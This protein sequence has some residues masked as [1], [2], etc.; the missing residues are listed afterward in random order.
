MPH[1]PEEIEYSDKYND[2]HYEYRHVI[3]TKD[4]YRKMQRNRLLLEKVLHQ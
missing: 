2:E 1:Y 4:V 3:L